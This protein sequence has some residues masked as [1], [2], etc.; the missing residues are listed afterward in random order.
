MV[1]MSSL[2]QKNETRLKR[3]GAVAYMEKSK[4]QL[5]SDSRPLLDVV[6]EALAHD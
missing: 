1:V 6:K 4:L 2:P 3:D 5:D